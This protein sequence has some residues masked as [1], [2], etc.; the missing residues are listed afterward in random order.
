M[1]F[2][3]L[4]C[5]VLCLALVASIANAASPGQIPD[6]AMAQFGLSGLQPMTDAQGLSVRGM[7][8]VTVS[9][10]SYASV[11]G[12]ASGTNN[13]ASAQGNCAFAFAPSAATA[14][15][16]LSFG[17]ICIKVGATAGGYAVGIAK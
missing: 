12:T 13:A 14:H 5:V 3:S 6:S 10:I 11:F 7:G 9:S 8:Y 15:A 16:T 2:L 1:R 17:P 4:V